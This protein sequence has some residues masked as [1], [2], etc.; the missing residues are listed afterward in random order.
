MNKIYVISDSHFGHSKMEEWALR[1]HG[2]E[3]K[4]WAGISR[5]PKDA[6]LIHLGD[7]SMG[8]DYDVESRLRELPFKKW[9]IRGN[10][11]QHSITWYVNHGWDACADL[12]VLD[13]FGGRLLLTHE[14]KRRINSTYG[15]YTKNVHGHL[16]GGKSRARPDFYDENY[17]VEV[18]PEVIGYEPAKLG[19]V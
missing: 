7:V 8:A 3:E 4:I 1:P 12:M 17:H 13:L 10:H 5:L 19:N 6:I 16:H 2:F 14:P 15:D 18:C 9:L 11:D